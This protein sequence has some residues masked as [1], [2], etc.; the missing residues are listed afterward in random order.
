MRSKALVSAQNY[1]GY[2]YANGQGVIKDVQKGMEWFRMAGDKN[3]NLE[4]IQKSELVKYSLGDTLFDGSIVFYINASCNHGMAAYPEDEG[5]ALSW[6]EAKLLARAQGESWHLPSKE[7]LALLYEQKDIVGG[8]ANVNYWSNTEY[9]QNWVWHQCFSNGAQNYYGLKS[10]S[11]GTRE[12]FKVR[13]VRY[14]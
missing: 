4:D 13:A 8:F 3:A 5:E 12:K 6:I 14:F 7:E 10:F 2:A 9:D 1:I 11:I